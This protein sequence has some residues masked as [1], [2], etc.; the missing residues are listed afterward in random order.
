[1]RFASQWYD[2]HKA[3]LS[4][5]KTYD[6]LETYFQGGELEQAFRN[7]ALSQD[8]LSCTEAEWTRT[9]TYMMPQV[10]ALVGRYSP[11]GENAFYRLYLPIDKTVE[12]AKEL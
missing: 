5:I 2:R 3:E 10:R 4:A 1:M 9:K 7:F 11:L 12:K 8:K 6:E